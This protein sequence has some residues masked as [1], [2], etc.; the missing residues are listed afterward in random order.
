[1]PAGMSVPVGRPGRPRGIMPGGMSPGGIMPGGIPLPPWGPKRWMRRKMG[2]SSGA[3]KSVT[4][5][6][7]NDMGTRAAPSSRKTSTVQVGAPAASAN[8]RPCGP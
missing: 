4:S 5:S 8:S 6:G 3:E 1:M 7:L 2:E